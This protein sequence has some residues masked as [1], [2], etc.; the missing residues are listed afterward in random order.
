MVIV[1]AGQTGARAAETLREQGWLGP[2]VLIGDENLPPY[3]RPPL[4]KAVL[5]GEKT[6]A[7]GTILPHDFFARQHVDFRGGAGVTA[8]DRASRIVV[9]GDGDVVP[10]HRVLIAT[11]AEPRRLDIPGT[12]L[13]GV[14]YLRSAADAERI[15]ALLTPG[16]HI[17][18]AG[19]G[20]IG[21][22]AAAAAAQ[23]GATV[24]VVE[25]APRLVMR[26]VPP[27]IEERLAARHRA[28]GIDILLSR[29]I[30]EIAG[31]G[32]RVGEVRL[33]DGAV[34]ACDAVLIGVG[35]APRTAI[36]AAAGLALDNGIAVDRQLRT[37]DPDI[38]AAGDVCSFPHGVFDARI[39][40][41]SWK[42]ADDQGRHAARNMLGGAECYS[43]V[44]WLWS[45]Q[46]ELTIQV[47]GLPHFGATSVRRPAG[48]DGLL[49]FHLGPDGR[50]VGTSGIGPNGAIG[51]SVRLGQMMIERRLYP[52]PARLADPSVNLKLLLAA[53]AA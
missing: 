6:P 23:R 49:V 40:V 5:L 8:I 29:Q 46:Y 48:A 13:N 19:G 42:N 14:F 22:E 7:D 37:S 53:E 2:V 3:E 50:I 12:E 1:G 51:R 41:E 25:M 36:A 28:A 32:G 10:Y 45:D 27:E 4:S 33:D 17:V 16:R 39:R 38:F 52:D 20:F 44:P 11:G 26:A 31:E 15:A 24:T 34:L 35:I 9:L 43:V 30:A 21:L 18:I 47:A